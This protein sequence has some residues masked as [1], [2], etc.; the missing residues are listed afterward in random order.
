MSTGEK[1]DKLEKRVQSTLNGQKLKKFDTI[2]VE[3]GWTESQAIKQAVKLLVEKNGI[4]E[5]PNIKKRLT[6]KRQLQGHISGTMVLH[7]EKICERKGLKTAKALD[8][9][10]ELL[11]EKYEQP[12]K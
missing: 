1:I 12:K 2:C 10:I 3:N 5:Q 11:I 6:F 9:G 8:M 7:F 4:V